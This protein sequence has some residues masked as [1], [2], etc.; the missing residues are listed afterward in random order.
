MQNNDLKRGLV[1]NVPFREKD[2]AKALGARWDPE[3]K[4]WFVPKGADERPFQRWITPQGEDAA[5]PVRPA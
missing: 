3:L 1:L 5:P 4:K 2:Q